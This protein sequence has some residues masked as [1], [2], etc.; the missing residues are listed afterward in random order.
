[1]TRLALL[2]L[3]AVAGMALLLG[4]VAPATAQTPTLPGQEEPVVPAGAAV[5]EPGDYGYR[6]AE[7]G[8][9]LLLTAVGIGCLA[10][11]L[12]VVQTTEENFYFWTL[13][14][15][16]YDCEAARRSLLTAVI[17]EEQLTELGAVYGR[18]AGLRYQELASPTPAGNYQANLIWKDGGSS[19]FLVF[20][21]W[22]GPAAG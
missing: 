2:A 7:G 14:L 12:L 15:G 9:E 16:D 13:V 21:A 20:R 1:M 10:P 6:D 3:S 22:R 18:L 17:T 19:A 5:L 11:N 8:A 4:G